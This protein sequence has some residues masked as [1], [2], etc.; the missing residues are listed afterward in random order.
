MEYMPGRTLKQVILQDSPI[1]PVRAIDL[2]VQVLKAARFA[3]RRGIVHRDLKPHNVIVDDE[4][5]AKVTDFGIA[6]AGASDMT[7]TGS[8]M[9]TAQY[10]SPEQAQGQ[11]VSPQSDLYS[12][13]VILFELLTGHVPFDA[14]SAVTIAL[15]HVSEPAPPPSAYDPAVPPE[16]DAIVL[17]ALEKEPARR[18]QDADAFI[19]ALEEARESIL[20]RE[21]TGQRTASFPAAAVLAAEGPATA[22]EAA[23]DEQ[24]ERRRRVPWW[25]WVLALLAVGG[26]VAAIV[27]LTQTKQVAVPP[28]VGLQLQAAQERLERANLRSRIETVRS[29]RPVNEVVAQS[30]QARRRVEEKSVVVLNVSGGPGTVEVPAVDGGTVEEATLKLN[31]A[32]LRVDRQIDQASDSVPSGNVIKTSP[33]AG[34]DV[35]RGSSVNL[36]VST[37]PA[38]VTVPNVVGYARGD[39][40]STLGSAGFRTTVTEEESSTVRAGDVISQSPGGNTKAD[41][42]S[43]IALVVARAPAVTIPDVV[44]SSE[45]DATAA[46]QARGLEPRISRQPV[47]DPAQDG[48]VVAQRPDANTQ[49][50]SGRAVRIFVGSY[51]EPTPPDTGGGDNDNGNG[52]GGA[53]TPDEQQ[54]GRSEFGR[55]RGRGNG[56]ASG[57]AGQG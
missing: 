11:A 16:L 35:T 1:D 25:A 37:G 23:W 50:T 36:Y 52:D 44:G 33:P 28:V 56:D 22:E 17:W 57:G 54:P 46:L 15:K 55:G 27:L 51:T 29:T 53:T 20:G 41:P 42:G 31:N 21:H 2:T 14:E 45:E 10:L 12:V 32:G 7:E 47:D 43:T 5:R 24:P 8:I 39:A 19:H 3:H 18:P 13:G 9:G 48:I 26:A 38:Q 34:R 49:T 40:E 4:D 30:P 6:R